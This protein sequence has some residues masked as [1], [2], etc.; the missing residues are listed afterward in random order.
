MVTYTEGKTDGCDI[1][2]ARTVLRGRRPWHAR[3]LFAKASCINW[4]V[5][6]S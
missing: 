6:S 1:A 4:L 5:A 2:S 3:T